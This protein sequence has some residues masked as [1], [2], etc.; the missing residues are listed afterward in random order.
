MAIIIKEVNNKKLLKA[1]V[2]FPNELYQGVSQYTYPIIIDE[3]NTF[4]PDKNGAYEYCETI[5]FLAYENDRVVGRICGLI[6][7]AYNKKANVKHLRF[8]RLDMVDNLEVTKALFKAIINWGKAKG[9]DTL[10]GPIGFSDLDKQGFQVEGFEHDSMFI[11]IY[12]FPYYIKHL[13][14]LGFV[15]DVDWVEYKVYS[16]YIDP[17]LIKIANM[18]ES[19]WGFKVKKFKNIKELKPYIHEAFEMYNQAFE[20]LH[21]TV[22]IT[23]RQVDEAVNTYLKMMNFNYIYVTFDKHD[24]VAGIGIMAPSLRDGVNKAKGKL[25]PFGWYHLLKAMKKF[26]R[27][28]MYFVAVKPEYQDTGISAL[29]LVRGFEQA[30]KDGVKWADTGPELETNTAVL[31]IWN[32]FKSEQIRRRRCFIRKL[33]NL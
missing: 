33:E 10:N 19:R 25:Y 26:D 28:D 4:S 5:L 27:L 2:E 17:R 6:N 23:R 13:E 1:F 9:M 30:K 3:I 32:Y 14:A 8:T 21:G 22:P 12:N 20:P 16:D 18:V 29:M 7:H 31:S 15:K 11:T 24:K